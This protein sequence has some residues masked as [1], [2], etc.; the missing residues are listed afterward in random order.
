[1]L[2]IEGSARRLARR[3]EGSCQAALDRHLQVLV[4]KESTEVREVA[5]PPLALTADGRAIGEALPEAGASAASPR[6]LAL[7][8]ALQVSRERTCAARR[9]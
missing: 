1:M 7:A 4:L 3:R 2:H 6:E 8:L 5:V 9:R